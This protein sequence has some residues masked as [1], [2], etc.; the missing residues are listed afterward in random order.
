MRTERDRACPYIIAHARRSGTRFPA[1]P[2]TG[3]RPAPHAATVRRLLQHLDADALDAAISAYL[4]ARMPLPQQPEPPL[5]PALRAVAVDGKTVHGSRTATATAIQLLAAMD[6]HGVVLAQRQIA[7]KSN[8]IP[9]FQPLLKA[10]DLKN[11]VL[12]GDA[13]HTQHGHGAYLRKRGGRSP[14]GGV[15]HAPDCEEA[16][17]GAPLLDLEHA[18]NTAEN[19]ATRLC[20]LC[21]CAQEL[22][23]LLRG[24]DHIGKSGDS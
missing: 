12:T 21:G 4:Q 15:L 20:T 17:Q 10:I 1:D 6:H 3:I 13:L 24:F 18:L 2:L 22:T 23:P 5:K 14:A 16:P 19:P 11:T 8:E 9:S 7:S